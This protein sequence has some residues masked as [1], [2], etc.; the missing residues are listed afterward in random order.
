[1]EYIGRNLDNLQDNKGLELAIL[2]RCRH[3]VLES[4]KRN[5]TTTQ[6]QSRKDAMQRFLFAPD[7]KVISENVFEFGKYDYNPPQQYH[8]RFTF[9]KHF[10]GVIRQM[11]A[12][13]LEVARI[14]DTM[15]QVEFWVCNQERGKGFSLPLYKNNFY[16]DFVAEL[17]DGRFLVVEHKGQHLADNE[18][19]KAKSRIGNFWASTTGN[20]F[21]MT[22]M[23]RESPLQQQIENAITTQ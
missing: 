22:R 12:E 17:T 18:D 4:L 20:I 23:D 15:E 7:A 13:E 11:N 16:P 3:Q 6:E 19:S 2:W 1:M 10:Y 9:N 21:I 8:G 5:L 14:L